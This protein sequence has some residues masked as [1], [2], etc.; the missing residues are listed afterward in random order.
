MRAVLVILH[1]RSVDPAERNNRGKD[2]LVI[3]KLRAI[4][5]QLHAWRL[6]GTQLGDPSFDDLI[7]RR[8]CGQGVLNHFCIDNDRV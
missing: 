5:R 8:A 2:T 3:E 6:D 1:S 4:P 7:G